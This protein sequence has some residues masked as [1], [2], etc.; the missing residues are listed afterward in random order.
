MVRI[1]DDEFDAVMRNRYVRPMDFTGKP[2]KGFVY[3]LLS[4]GMPSSQQMKSIRS[5]SSA[6]SPAKCD[7]GGWCRFQQ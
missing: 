2:L 5:M 3:S 1:P 7:G 6:T 4:R